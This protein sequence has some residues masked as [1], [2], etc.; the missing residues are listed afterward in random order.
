MVDGDTAYEV[1]SVEA[2]PEYTGDF[3]LY[4]VLDGTDPSFVENSDL[5]QSLDAV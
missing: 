2:L 5:W 3:I 4:G 1:V